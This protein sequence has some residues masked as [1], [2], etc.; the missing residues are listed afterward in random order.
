[1]RRSLLALLGLLA[2][3]VQAAAPAL[4]PPAGASVAV[5]S[6][7]FYVSYTGNARTFSWDAIAGAASYEAEVYEALT[8]RVVSTSTVSATSLIWMPPRAGFYVLH[9]RGAGGSAWSQSTD[10]AATNGKPFWLL[11]LVKP[12]SDGSIT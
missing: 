8:G 4:N 10:P 1:M 5:A 12:P 6:G 11:V 9:V 7:D 2:L 3:S